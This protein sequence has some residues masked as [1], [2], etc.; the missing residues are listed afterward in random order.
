MKKIIILL[1]VVVLL[2]V[3]FYSKQKTNPNRNIR[4][5][6][7]LSLTGGAS[8]WGENAKKGIELAVE[9][10][11]NSGGVDGRKFEIVYEDTASDPKIAVSA[12]QKI[13]QVDRIDFIL[14]PLNQTEIASV[15]SLIDQNNIPAVIPGYLPLEQR[16]NINN[17]IFFWTDAQF[18]AGEIAKYVYNQGLRNVAVIGTLDSWENTVT[19]GFV[20][21]FKELGG[22][23]TDIEQVQ[24]DSSDM[25]L[26]I[27]KILAKKPEAVFLGTYYQFVNST[28]EL[29]NQQYKGRLYSIEV[30]DYLATET[31][32]W[33]N[34]LH[35]ISPNYYSESFINRFKNRYGVVPGVPTGQA[36]DSVWVLFNVIGKNKQDTLDNIKNFKSY[37]GVS[38][39]FSIDAYGR[40]SLPLAIFK[41]N[42]GKIEKVEDL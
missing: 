25:K 22:S 21:K 2:V 5:G 19:I 23:I 37:D 16:K 4:I 36:Y 33:S 15:I 26:P 29:S 1:L 27:T 18:E 3:L 11:N 13:N 31:Y 39:K 34:D 6:A 20:S 17:P 10:I 8:A 14:G 24:P 28:K 38:G 41:I 35:F 42:N 12:F 30:D 7:L 40:G 32:K 9:E